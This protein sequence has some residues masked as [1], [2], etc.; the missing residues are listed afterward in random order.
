MTKSQA[1]VTSK[2]P[3]IFFIFLEMVCA[4]LETIMEIATASVSQR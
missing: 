2:T 4:W 1:T 3:F